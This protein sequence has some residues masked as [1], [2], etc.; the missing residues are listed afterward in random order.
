MKKKVINTLLC[1]NYNILKYLFCFWDSKLKHFKFYVPVKLKNQNSY[2][3]NRSKHR[4][5]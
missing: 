3:L 2:L 5:V 4:V 1:H